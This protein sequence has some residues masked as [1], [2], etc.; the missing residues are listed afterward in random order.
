MSFK[1]FTPKRLLPLTDRP[2]IFTLCGLIFLTLNIVGCERE[3][4]VDH[5]AVHHADFTGAKIGN[6]DYKSVRPLFWSQLYANG[7]QTLYCDVRF[8]SNRGNGFNIEHVVPMASVVATFDCGSRKKCRRINAKFNKIEADLHN[9]FPVQ[10]TINTARSSFA[11]AEIDGEMRN[12]GDCDFEVNSSRAVVEPALAVRGE[13][14]R[15]TLYMQDTY[16]LAFVESRRERLLQ[17]H[18]DDPVSDEER[19]RN[20]VIEAIQGTRNG[21]IDADRQASFQ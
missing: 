4:S 12:Y 11:F 9:L 1:R 14:A 2:T 6:L 18:R 20:D 15:A 10:T 21:W 8:G 17:W 16:G 3:E 5:Q 13:I 19:R 7:G